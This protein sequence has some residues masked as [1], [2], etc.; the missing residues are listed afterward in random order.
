MRY[1]LFAVAMIVC[2][3]F[4]CATSGDHSSAGAP[5]AAANVAGSWAG[6][7][8]SGG[9]SA[10]VFMELQ[11]EGAKVTGKVRASGG[12]PAGD[13]EGTVAGDKFTYSL[14]GGR[15]C[16]AELTVRGDEMRGRGASGY[17]VQVQRMK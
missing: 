11:Q 16:C 14:N 5:T 17:A 4:G 7:V 10:D 1:P 12:G 8:G 6:S 13:L 15:T 2:L 3:A 9:F